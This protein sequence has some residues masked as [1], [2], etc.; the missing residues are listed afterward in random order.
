MYKKEEV[1]NNFYKKLAKEVNF[2]KATLNNIP[3]YALFYEEN[4]EP[5]SIEDNIK[6]H[7]FY[8]QTE[9][10]WENKI[11]FIP[12]NSPLEKTE[13]EL[14]FSGVTPDKEPKDALERYE[15]SRLLPL[16][17]PS[18]YEDMLLYAGAIWHLRLSLLNC[19]DDNTKQIAN[20]LTPFATFLAE[21][22]G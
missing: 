7:N 5:A 9:S 10:L 14:G 15:N 4:G 12:K 19:V 8:I 6:F 22:F 2:K 21:F 3:T 13:E 20:Q 16:E 11:K 18:D 1:L 17:N